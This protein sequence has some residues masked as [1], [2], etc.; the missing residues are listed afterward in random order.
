MPV[1]QSCPVLRQSINKSGYWL[2]R[3]ISYKEPALALSGAAV[4]AS[5]AGRVVAQ[6]MK[7]GTTSEA[8]RDGA[9]WTISLPGGPYVLFFVFDLFFLFGVPKILPKKELHRSLQVT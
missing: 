5:W 9:A 7:P 2:S 3:Q 8:A 6:P 1:R 4:W